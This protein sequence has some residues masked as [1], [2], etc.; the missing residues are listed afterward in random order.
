MF[1]RNAHLRASG[2]SQVSEESPGSIASYGEK[3]NRRNSLPNSNMKNR[4]L[5]SS[6]ERSTYDGEG[7]GRSRSN[8][9]NQ[10]FESGSINYGVSRNED[11]PNRPKIGREQEVT[12]QNDVKEL[13][14]GII[15]DSEVRRDSREDTFVVS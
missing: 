11:T 12:Y 15:T 6:A 14:V 2:A 10:P 9:G 1:S 7:P 13:P 5:K 3:V 8:S 4:E